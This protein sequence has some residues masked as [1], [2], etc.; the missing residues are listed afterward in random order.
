MKKPTVTS[1]DVARAA[2]VSPGASISD[3]TRRRVVRAAE[4]LG[5]R[6]NALARVTVALAPKESYS[7]PGGAWRALANRGSTDVEIAVITATDG[8][9]A[10]EW[11]PEVLCAA[12]AAGFAL[13]HNGYVAPLHLLPMSVQMSA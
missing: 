7:I 1:L 13:D 8:K 10:I 6:P 9:K 11:A 4:Q 5:Y 3:E 2:E 12:R